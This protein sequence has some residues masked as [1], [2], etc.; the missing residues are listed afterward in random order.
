MSGL[1]P[2]LFDDAHVLA[3]NKPS[4]LLIAPDRWDKE[5]EN[6]MDLVHR[7]LSP[8]IFNVHRLDRDTS[9]LVLCAK[10]KSALDDLCLQFENGEV[11][12]EY[13]ALVRGRPP[14]VLGEIDQ[15]LVE[16]PMKPGRMKAVRHGK[17]ALTHYETEQS[18]R[19]WT[20]LRL[21]PQTGRMHQLRVHMKVLGCPIVGD[22]WYG[23]G[24]PLLLSEIKRGYKPGRLPERPLLDHLALHAHRLAFRHPAIGERQTIEAPMPD[25]FQ[26][27]IK[28]L[29]RWA[30]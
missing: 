7:Q 19:G 16:D 8:D 23:D 13:V 20:L 28:Q 14:A 17:P 3:I 4:G 9:G 18:F 24:R 25:D 26:L 29:A 6:L 5:L 12:K 1:P 22:P 27:A 11:E 10:T 30:V 15:P 2:I 21:R